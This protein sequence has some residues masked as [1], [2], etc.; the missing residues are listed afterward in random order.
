M[1]R[2][3]RGVGLGVSQKLG[4]EVGTGIGVLVNVGV[5]G[6]SCTW[7]VC[8]MYTVFMRSGVIA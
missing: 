7:N 8:V 1:N 3:G 5:A 4:V 2:K 6:S